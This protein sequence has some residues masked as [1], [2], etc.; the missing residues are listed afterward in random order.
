MSETIPQ[1]NPTLN[2]LRDPKYKKLEEI[3]ARIPRLACQRKCQ[4]ACGLV[5]ATGELEEERLYAQTGRFFGTVKFRHEDGQTRPY[6]H[7]LS[8]QGECSV[9]ALRPLMCRLFGVIKELECPHGCQPERWLSDA[10]K[11]E[12]IREVEAL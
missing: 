4:I 3:Y 11:L 9:Y 10:E 1:S 7:F 2:V 8:E 12:L 6:C 5:D